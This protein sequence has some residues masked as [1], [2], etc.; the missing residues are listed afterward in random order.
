[1]GQ[2]PAI[3][4][5]LLVNN[6]SISPWQTWKIFLICIMLNHLLFAAQRSSGETDLEDWP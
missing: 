6:A 1:M 4:T 5:P 3:L 2:N